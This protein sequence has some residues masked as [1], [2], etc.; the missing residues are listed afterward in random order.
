MFHLNTYFVTLSV[1]EGEGEGEGGP[2]PD[3][4]AV[5]GGHSMDIRSLSLSLISFSLKSAS[6]D[7]LDAR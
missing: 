5:R 1:G 2:Q 7:L 6:G 4:N 3:A